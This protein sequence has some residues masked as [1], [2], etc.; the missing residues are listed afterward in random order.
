MEPL[1][2]LVLL[3]LAFVLLVPPILALV[4]LSR[5]NRAASEIAEIRNKLDALGWRVAAARRARETEAAP[6]IPSEPAEAQGTRAAAEPEAARATAVAPI[7]SEPIAR[8]APGAVPASPPTA[9]PPRAAPPAPRPPLPPQPRAAV[10]DFA[11]NLGPRILVATGGLAVV[12]FLA[13][14]VRYAWEN[15]WVGPAGRVLMGAVFSLGLVAAG[16]RHMSREYRPLGQ[17]LAAAGFAGLYV[18]AFAA[19]T[20]YGLVPR[21]P[22]A[23]FMIA[24]TVCAVVVADRM[25]GR[26]LAG[27]AWIGAYLAPVLLSTGEDRAESLFAYLLLLGAGA[28]WLDRRQPWPETTPLALAGTLLLYAGWYGSFF[29]PERFEVAAAGLVLLTGLFALGA[30]RKERPAGFAL[31]VL[32]AA[33]GV[34]VLGAGADRPEVLLPLSLVLAAVALRSARSF[35][36]PVALAAGAAV[37]VPFLTW[38]ATHYRPETFGAAAA[39]IGGGSLLL[40]LAAPEGSL[41]A[42]VFPAGSLVAGGF[43]AAVLAGRTDRPMALLALLAAQAGLAVLVERRWPWA[44][45][46]GSGLAAVAVFLWFE[47]Y[48]KPDRG[49]EALALGLTVAGLYLLALVVRS[50]ALAWPLGACGAVAHLVVAFLAWTLLD[51]VLSATQAALLGPAAA[52]LAALYL[53]LGLAARHRVAEDGL[54]VRVT[55]GL[56]AAF[57]TLAIPV[58]LGLHGITLA[59]AVE[60][61]LLLWLGVAHA[62]T[63]A[64]VFGYAVLTLA[65]G[66]L[67]VRHLPLHGGPFMPVLNPAFAIW[68]AVIATLFGAWRLARSARAAGGRIDEPMELALAPLALLLLFGL[69]TV[70]TQSVFDQAA[71]TATAAG[72]G[73]GALRAHRE[74]GLA[75]SV[76]WTVFATALLAAGLGLRSRGLFY[77]AYALFGI[78]AAKVVLIDLATLPTLYRMLS[79]LALGVLLLAGA[80]LNLRFRGRLALPEPPR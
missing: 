64:R 5:A 66:R 43:A 31:V 60:G 21:G 7:P 76:L 54:Q 68:L 22:A 61:L 12:V 11:T 75:V 45:A 6:P 37:A 46:A 8:A 50:L 79:F 47:R 19:H 72:D 10:S 3:A 25:G 40:A 27:L 78:T 58:Q 34:S 69:L 15:D 26:L 24:V 2:G 51:R 20:V 9:G 41:P 44:K 29:R 56:A 39:W 59:W 32:L 62:S 30:A 67:F 33:L 16:L 17:G 23:A 4:A 1:I 65:V 71:R 74:G 55:L 42:A 49:A 63:L 14:F 48:F 53:A 70:E 36:L 38:A 18:T 80:W 13:L 73:A 35:G 57:L 52:A 77:A 28:L